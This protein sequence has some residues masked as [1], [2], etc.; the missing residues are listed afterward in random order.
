MGPKNDYSETRSRVVRA[1]QMMDHARRAAGC[2]NLPPS[3]AP[4]DIREQIDHLQE[5]VARVAEELTE[6]RAACVR[7]GRRGLTVCS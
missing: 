3:M 1:T 7:A 6:A 2:T 5:L 4:A